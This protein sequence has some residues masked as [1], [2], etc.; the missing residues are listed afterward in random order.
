MFD[1]TSS[2]T[3]KKTCSS[4]SIS[5]LFFRERD[6]YA[7]IRSDNAELAYI[8]MDTF[9]VVVYPVKRISWLGCDIY[10][11]LKEL[12]KHVEAGTLPPVTYYPDEEPCLI[13]TPSGA[14]RCSF[15][16]HCHIEDDLGLTFIADGPPR[17]FGELASDYM[18]LKREIDGQEKA[19]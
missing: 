11:Q 5:P 15:W 8:D 3:A 1:N 9:R 18:E 13:Y 4:T 17:G 7:S 16:E 14:K 6:R 2:S 19:I 12:H 10:K